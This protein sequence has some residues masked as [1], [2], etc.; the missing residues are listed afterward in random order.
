MWKHS[1]FCS[2]ISCSTVVYRNLGKNLCTITCTQI[3]NETQ[4]KYKNNKKKTENCP[5]NWYEIHEKGGNEMQI[6]YILTM[7]TILWMSICMF[8][9][10]LDD[11]I[12]GDGMLCS[13]LRIVVCRKSQT[14]TIRTWIFSMMFILYPPKNTHTHI[15]HLVTARKRKIADKIENANR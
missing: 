4:N 12:L 9:R 2:M 7:T 8:G 5:Q 1:L 15:V 14:Q 3:W 6:K 13:L 10:L 11:T